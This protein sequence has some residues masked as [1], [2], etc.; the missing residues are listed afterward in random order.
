ML[1]ITVYIATS[2]RECACEPSSPDRRESA[3]HGD[4]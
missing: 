1:R 3:A 2:M 4:V